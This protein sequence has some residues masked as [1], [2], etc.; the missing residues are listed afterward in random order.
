MSVLCWKVVTCAF[1]S[2]FINGVRETTLA[3]AGEEGLADER[4]GVC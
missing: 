1:E 3:M 2:L 4:G